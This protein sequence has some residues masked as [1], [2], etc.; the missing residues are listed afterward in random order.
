[1][2]LQKA[3]PVKLTTALVILFLLLPF[4]STETFSSNKKQTY[5]YFDLAEAQGGP[6]HGLNLD[7][8]IPLN[9]KKQKEPDHQQDLARQKR[10]ADE[11]RHEHHH[12]HFDK[13]K[14]RK[15]FINILSSVALKLFIAVSYISVLL[16]SYMSICH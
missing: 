1:M 4:R 13:V 5:S 7:L 15:K 12:H 9:N 6:N 2:T 10:H 11:D 16:C 3:L 14:T 8:T